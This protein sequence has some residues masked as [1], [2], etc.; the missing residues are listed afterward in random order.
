[1][2][3][4]Q[5]FVL[6]FFSLDFAIS[7][8]VIWGFALLMAA[9]LL[10]LP[11]FSRY[12][13][14]KTGRVGFSDEN[15]IGIKKFVYLAMGVIAIISMFASA[16]A[17]LFYIP[18]LLET[19]IKWLSAAYLLV[20][21][22]EW[23]RISLREFLEC[24]VPFYAWEMKKQKERTEQPGKLTTKGAAKKLLI[25]LVIVTVLSVIL[26]GLFS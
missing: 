14:K 2:S 9:M 22:A 17:G 25:A 1:M 12:L 3:T 8:L 16:T 26:S 4:W 13:E 15:I 6:T 21:V 23:R 7:L 18:I 20:T 5:L 11:N 19:S 24:I 10:A